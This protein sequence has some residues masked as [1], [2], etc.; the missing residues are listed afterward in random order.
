MRHLLFALAL[1]ASGLAG[2]Q[3]LLEFR[4]DLAFSPAEVAAQGVR[5]YG[6]RLQTLKMAGKLDPDP[7]L[8]ARLQ[9]IV[10]LLLR[11]ANRS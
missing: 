4:D 7:E 9:R 3:P 2:A 6:A 5:A 11:A 8:K 1:T 10:P